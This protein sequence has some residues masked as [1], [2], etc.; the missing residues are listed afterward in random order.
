MHGEQADSFYR[1]IG[2][3]LHLTVVQLRKQWQRSAAKRVAIH[4]L[5]ETK[6]RRAVQQDYPCS[7]IEKYW[8]CE[9]STARAKIFGNKKL[10]E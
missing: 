1:K 5:V 6:L 4:F 8:N 10:T 7:L 2:Q 9:R 3:K